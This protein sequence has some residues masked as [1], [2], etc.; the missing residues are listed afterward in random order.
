M[1][2]P[3]SPMTS[4]DSKVSLY[5]AARAAVKDREDKA[6]ADRATHPVPPGR[7]KRMG[8]LGL[9]GIVG[10]ALLVIRPAWLAGPRAVPEEPPALAAASLRL[11]LIRER[12]RVFDFLQ[13]TGRLPGTLVE[14]GGQA[15]GIHYTPGTDQTFSLAGEAGDSLI[16]LHSADSLTTFLGSSL[17]AVRDRGRQ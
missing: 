15:P 12:Q 11:T 2:G 16:T 5:E 9:I 7:R 6:E 17:Q 3:R 13:R 4:R 14:A 1:T 10:L 8:V